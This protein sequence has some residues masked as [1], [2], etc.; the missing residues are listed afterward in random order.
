[1]TKQNHESN[2]NYSAVESTNF[3]LVAL[4]HLIIKLDV[5]VPAQI[6]IYIGVVIL[7]SPAEGGGNCQTIWHTLCVPSTWYVYY[8][9]PDRAVGGW[10]FILVCF[11]IYQYILPVRVV[12]GCDCISDYIGLVYVRVVAGLDLVT[13]PLDLHWL[14][15]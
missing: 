8:I 3:G 7:P 11:S 14:R 12:G 5:R 13:P 6:Q 10:D 9:L 4:T 1:M 15:P 2:N